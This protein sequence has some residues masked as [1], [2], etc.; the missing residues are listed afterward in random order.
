MVATRCF[1]FN[2][3]PYIE[4]TLRGFTM[5]ETDFPIVYCIVDD[6]STDGEPEIIRKW[7]NENLEQN[8]D[9]K[10]WKDIQYGDIAEASLKGKP[11]VKFAILLLKENYYSQHKAKI[12]LVMEWISNSKYVAICEGD[13]YWI[14]NRKLQRQVD[15]LERNNDISMCFH[16]AIITYED[17]PL[18][19]SIFNNIGEDRVVTLEELIKKWIVPTASMVYRSSILPVFPIE[20]KIVSGDWRMILHCAAHGRVWALK[21][22]MSVYRMAFHSGSSTSRN[23]GKREKMYHQYRRILESFD[24]YTNYEYHHLV[25]KYCKFWNN[26]ERFVRLRERNAFLAVLMMPFFAAGRLFDKLKKD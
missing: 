19:A 20:G 10:L 16:N 12:P 21:N 5:Q 6:A 24:T 13:D 4:D 15:C 26:Y 11:L 8:K 9:E 1:T 14:D 25:K 22:V 7:A 3:A 2:H 17:K 18:P 23:S